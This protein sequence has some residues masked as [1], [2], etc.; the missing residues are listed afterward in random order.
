ML[1]HIKIFWKCLQQMKKQLLKSMHYG[2]AESA[3]NRR[4]LAV[5]HNRRDT[6]YDH[7]YL[8]FY[9]IQKNMEW[10]VKRFH[11]HIKIDVQSLEQVDVHLFWHMILIIFSGKAFYN[12][13]NFQRIFF[14]MIYDNGHFLCR[15]FCLS[16]LF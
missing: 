5:D 8:L 1:C 12:I 4:H 13:I 6:Q 3:W 9:E 7:E 15:F 10:E 2:I 16:C 11:W 14:V